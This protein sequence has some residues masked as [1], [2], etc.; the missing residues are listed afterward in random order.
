MTIPEF[1]K[2]CKT[3]KEKEEV[4]KKMTNEE[5]QSLIDTSTSIYGKIFYKKFLKK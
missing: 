4:L 5:I 3:K 2:K 1:Q